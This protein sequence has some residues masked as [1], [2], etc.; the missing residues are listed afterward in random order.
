MEDIT[1]RKRVETELAQA[2]DAALESVRLKSEF[3]ANMSHEIRTP[4][5]AVIGM[6]ELLLETDLTPEQSELART[7][8]SSADLL[9]TILND[10]LDF[11]KIEAGK[12]SLEKED[13]D[14]RQVIED[15]LELLAENAHAKGLELAG[16]IPPDTPTHF[17][18]DA[19]RIRQVLTNLVGNAIK[20][21]ESGEVVIQVSEECR[22]TIQITVRL[23]ILDTGIGID[24][25]TQARLFQSFTQAD[26]STTRKYGGTGLGLAICKRLVEM[27]EGEIGIQ[28]KL[29]GGSFF[30]FTV[31][32]K[33][34]VA[35]SG[36]KRQR[37]DS[38][39]KV[40]V[41]VVD[42]NATNGRVL[43]NQLAALK[44][45]D[46]YA[47]SGENALLMLHAA[48][49]AD[50]PYRLAILDMDDYLSKPMRIDDL[51]AALARVRAVAAEN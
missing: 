11:S 22:D 50:T 28:S 17:C 10:I 32:L 2:R 40:K 3:L 43:H 13:F 5:N 21:T 12:L 18:G 33:R 23:Q 46:D 36:V 26:G 19:G 24:P 15:T 48:A 47:S 45:P 35:P 49:A 44:M 9:S 20:F 27:M 14:L 7:V 31:K 16:L 4:M 30:W 39:A 41:L 37:T 51:S 8:S 38:L 42:D 25:E 1:K 6:S 34:P 29:G